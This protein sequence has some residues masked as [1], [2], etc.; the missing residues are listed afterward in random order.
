MNIIRDISKD[1]STKG[2]LYSRTPLNH[3]FPPAC[4]FNRYINLFNPPPIF[5]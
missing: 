2:Y 5:N 4:H 1:S 3:H